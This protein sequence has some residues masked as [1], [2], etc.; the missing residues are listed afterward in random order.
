MLLDQIDCAILR[1]LQQNARLSNKELSEKIGLSPSSTLER[2]KRL[3]EDGIFSGF[4]AELSP[5]KVGIGLQAMISVRLNKHTF[6]EVDAF[7]NYAMAHPTVVSAYHVAGSND[8]LLHV[9][10]RDSDHLRSLVLSAFTTRPEVVHI[11]TALIYEYT[12]SHETPIYLKA[13]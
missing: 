6:Q 10:V 9:A 4:H 8:F 12:R 7:R 1:E 13:I 3:Q 5:K 11:E 2:T